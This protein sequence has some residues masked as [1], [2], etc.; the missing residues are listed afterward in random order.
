VLRA[1]CQEREQSAAVVIEA[2]ARALA[3][4]YFSLDE[5]HPTP[6]GGQHLS[7]ERQQRVLDFIQ[8]NLANPGLRVAHLAKLVAL[9]PPHFTEVFRHT[10]G[11]PPMEQVRRCR[12]LQ[13]H[14]LVQTRNHRMGEIADACGFCDASH[15]GREF[16]N[17][18]GYP[19]R[20]LR[21]GAGPAPRSG[22]L[23]DHSAIT[24]RS[25]RLAALT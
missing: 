7:P 8:Q 1:L 23:P 21:G 12:L 22:P 9:S 19:P 4:R 20:L 14:Q 10:L 5:K 18:F 11:R 3:L 24:A 15:L 6:T 16:R 2:A 13:A 25:G 17:F